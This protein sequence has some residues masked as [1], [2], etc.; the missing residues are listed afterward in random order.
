M[1]LSAA[2]F[3]I[4][5]VQ[6]QFGGG[7]NPLLFPSMTTG[8]VPGSI[9]SA[10][11]PLSSGCGNYLPTQSQESYRSASSSPLARRPSS[12]FDIGNEGADV[13]ANFTVADE[14]TNICASAVMTDDEF[15]DDANEDDFD[16]THG[17]A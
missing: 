17:E 12:D 16:D 2:T 11:A 6:V 14:Y 15:D 7:D 1:A 13:R 8:V 10:S 3:S 5:F 9:D 4:P